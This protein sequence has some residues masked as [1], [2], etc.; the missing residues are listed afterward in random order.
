MWLLNTQLEVRQHGGPREERSET[1]ASP[2]G[3]LTNNTAPFL[4]LP[5]SISTT[6]ALAVVY[7]CSRVWAVAEAYVPV[8]R[9]DV[10]VT[11]DVMPPLPYTVP[12]HELRGA[13]VAVFI[14]VPY[15][16]G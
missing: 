16:C 5:G 12:Q 7:R 3:G 4:R 14:E 6:A 10:F 8:Q 2:P 1:G 9:G 13:P 11:G 15:P